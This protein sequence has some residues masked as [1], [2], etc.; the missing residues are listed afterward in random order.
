MSSETRL[1]TR[2][3]LRAQEVAVSAGAMLRKAHHRRRTVDFK[4][5]IDLVTEMD[6]RVER[7][8]GRELSRTFP[9]FDLLA[10]EALR[11]VDTGSE[12]RWVVDPLDGTTNYA[13]GLPIYSVSIALEHRGRVV[14]GV[15][16]QPVL[17]ELFAAQK[18]QGAR[19]NGRRIAVSA[20][21]RLEHSLLVTGFPY[22]MHTTREDNL[23]YFRRFVKRAR[24]VRR[25]GS[26]AIDL[27][28]VACGRF[29]GYWELK[30]SPWDVAAGALIAAEAGA[31]ITTMAGRP[32]SIYDRSVLAAPP[33]LHS[34]ML[35]VLR[36]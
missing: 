25:L 14:A 23:N 34:I 26:A 21:K 29:D 20:G 33:A 7:F 28:Y 36:D 2:G 31:R 4:G 15:V 30:L 13:H 18:G 17:D 27:C 3:R 8:I 1:Y 35:G 5:A 10:E 16:Y 32:F 11:N 9:S 22:D 19:L 24:A 12:F 6:R